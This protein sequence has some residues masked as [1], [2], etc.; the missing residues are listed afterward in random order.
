MCI[1]STPQAAP[2]ASHL[3]VARAS[4]RSRGPALAT[5]GGGACG[6]LLYAALETEPN[7][8]SVSLDG[9]A[10]ALLLSALANMTSG[11]GRVSV[12]ALAVREDQ[13]KRGFMV[14]ALLPPL[15]PGPA[16]GAVA[17]DLMPGGAPLG[18]RYTRR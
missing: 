10:P 7:L 12:G 11:L 14:P 13:P 1:N 6:V 4:E 17:A 18:L 15:K 5:L 3:R 16:G 9:G 8:A 2:T